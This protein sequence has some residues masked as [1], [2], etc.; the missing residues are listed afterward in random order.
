MGAAQAPTGGVATRVAPTGVAACVLWDRVAE[1]PQSVHQSLPQGW[2][3]VCCGSGASRD[4]LNPPVFLDRT[5]G[6]VDTA[7]MFAVT[8]VACWWWTLSAEGVAG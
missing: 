3:R 8:H 6:P 2:R 7:A 1:S 5:A 4:T